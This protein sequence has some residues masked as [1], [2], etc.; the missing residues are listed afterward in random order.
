M[1]DPAVAVAGPLFVTPT[2]ALVLTGVVTLAV[3]LEGSKSGLSVVAV[4]VLVIEVV[5]PTRIT[6]VKTA[7]AP[8]AIAVQKHV[9]V[10]VPPT[11]GVEHGESGAGPLFWINDTNVVFGGS[12]S[13]SWTLMAVSDSP[14]L[15]F[16][17]VNV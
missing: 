14:L 16:E 13:L 3:L 2:S 17:T 12:V 9:T 11:S 5:S 8:L 7:E 6:S 4:S 10:P 15:V 1:L